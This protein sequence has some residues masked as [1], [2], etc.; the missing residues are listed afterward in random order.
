MQQK[1][2]A[3]FPS[4]GCKLPAVIPL[5]LRREDVLLVTSRE[6]VFISKLSSKRSSRNRI[7]GDSFIKGSGLR[8]VPWVART[9]SME[10]GLNEGKHFFF[11]PS[12][13]CSSER[14]GAR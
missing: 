3:I 9:T 2:L 12:G 13:G 8:E 14:I 10:R 4:E 6:N 5:S 1:S 11:L 7:K